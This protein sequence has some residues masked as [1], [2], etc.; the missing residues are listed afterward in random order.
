MLKGISKISTNCYTEVHCCVYPNSSFFKSQIIYCIFS[1]SCCLSIITETSQPGTSAL[2]NARV[3]SPRS[4]K[5][6]SIFPSQWSGNIYPVSIT[7]THQSTHFFIFHQSD[8]CCYCFCFISLSIYYL[9]LNWPTQNST[10]LVNF[11]SCQLNPIK[12]WSVNRSPSSS[13]THYHS[14]F[15]RFLSISQRHAS[16]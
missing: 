6:N 3:S 16:H 2:W 12:S 11:F 9:K 5:G 1:N 14:H 8:Y 10:C 7:I 15:N 4:N 13:K